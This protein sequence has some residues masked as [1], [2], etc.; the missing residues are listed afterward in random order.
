MHD[1][2]Y[3]I[4]I[5]PMIND[6]MDQS[7]VFSFQKGVNV[8]E[9]HT[10][11]VSRRKQD[12]SGPESRCGDEPLRGK[13]TPTSWF[14]LVVV[15]FVFFC[16]VFFLQKKTK[17]PSWV[18]GRV[19]PPAER[20]SSGDNG[21]SVSPQGRVVTK[22]SVT[23]RREFI[24]VTSHRNDF[25]G[26]GWGGSKPQILKSNPFSGESNSV[27]EW[28]GSFC[29]ILHPPL[30]FHSM[31]LKKTGLSTILNPAAASS[32][33]KRN[34]A[35]AASL[36]RTTR[37][38]RTRELWNLFIIRDHGENSVLYFPV[39]WKEESRKRLRIRYDTK[40]VWH[41]KIRALF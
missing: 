34:H 13:V 25:G 36:F 8:F 2:C 31:L 27:V 22:K 35:A 24:S 37:R 41:I 11:Y 40:Q 3:C 19:A 12:C 20:V 23:V 33:R 30:F 14:P 28:D 26:F 4:Q 10:Q 5:I 18:T 32:P 17:T 6:E 7:K 29:P 38:S 9:A 1:K 16:L 39:E 15:L 21:R